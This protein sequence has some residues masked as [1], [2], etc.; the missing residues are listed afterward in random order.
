MGPRLR[1]V[2]G[3]TQDAR[4]R[5]GL[6]VLLGAGCNDVVPATSGSSSD[7][8]GSSSGEGETSASTHASTAVES[9]GS[10][11]SDGS[12][13]GGESSSDESSSTGAM[14]TTSESSSS[15]SSTSESS[16][17]SG[18]LLDCG[19]L[20]IDAGEACDGDELA[21]LDCTD[22]GFQGGSL[23][24]LSDC[25]DF[26]ASACGMFGGDCCSEH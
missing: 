11:S 3:R 4:V 2:P 17:E 22:F 7:G 9:S 12:S 21:G 16:S 6:V 23:A 24:C 14:A 15:E 20:F 1:C 8:G 25:S 10:D 13:S 18:A 19:N 26:D 5:F